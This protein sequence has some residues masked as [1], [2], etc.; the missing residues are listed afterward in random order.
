M[1]HIIPAGTGFDG[2]RKLNLKP[3]VDPVE[4]DEETNLLL[5]PETEEPNPL[6]G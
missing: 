4:M 5:A 6:V 2:H 3:L 1:G